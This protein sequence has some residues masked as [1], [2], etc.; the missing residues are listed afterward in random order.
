MMHFFTHEYKKKAG[1]EMLGF[2]MIAPLIIVL[3]WAIVGAA[4]IASA[5]QKLNYCVYNTC[6]SAAISDCYED[7]EIKVK[8]LYELHFGKENYLEHGYTPVTLDLIGDKDEWEKGKY[9]KCTVR[10]YVSTLAP[11]ASGVRESS[12]VMMIENGE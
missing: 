11:F 3:I 1:G 5:N 8:E 2:V 4:Q 10:Y 9:V 12:I 7:A 6:R